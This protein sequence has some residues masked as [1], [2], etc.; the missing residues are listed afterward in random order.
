MQLNSKNSLIPKIPVQTT[1]SLF[2]LLTGFARAAF[3]AWK[4]M[5]I[6]ATIIAVIADSINTPGPMVIR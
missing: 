3:I 2:K 5:V 6:N 1:Y 4:L